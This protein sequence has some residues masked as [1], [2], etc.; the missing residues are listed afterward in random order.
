MANS[1]SPARSARQKRGEKITRIACWLILVLFLSTGIYLLSAALL[2]ATPITAFSVRYARY[3]LILFLLSAAAVVALVIR[4]AGWRILISPAFLIPLGISLVGLAVY[5]RILPPDVIH[6]E[7]IYANYREGVRLFNGI[8][9]YERILNEEMTHNDDYATYLPLFYY[10]T[11]WT[12]NPGKLPFVRWVRFWQ[13]IFILFALAV[14]VLLFYIPY[15]R[16]MLLLGV[17]GSLFWLFNRWTLH[18]VQS[19]DIDALLLFFLILSLY[20]LPRRVWVSGLLLGISLAIKQVALILVPVYLILVWRNAVTRRFR[21]V[22]ILCIAIGLIPLLV[23]LQFIFWNWQAF[24]KGLLFSA[25][26]NPETLWGL[27]SVE[28]MLGWSGPA[29]RLAM[30]VMLVLSY[31]LAVKMKKN[32]FSLALLILSIFVFFNPVFFT[33]YMVL[34]VPFIPLAIYELLTPP[35]QATIA[36]T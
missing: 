35:H 20:F 21:Q 5:T 4:L 26:R 6:D 16:Q 22:A 30:L 24:A 28:A 18:L 36:E 34:V 19:A 10:L 17:I 33:N 12:V 7:D 14:G 2:K 3:V 15:R 25:T 13:I 1:D 31:I 32:V 29:A 8:N 27:N 9:P 23:S 11:R